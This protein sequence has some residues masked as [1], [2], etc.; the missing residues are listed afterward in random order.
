[1]APANN[2]PPERL[3]E[4]RAHPDFR[5]TVEAHCARRVQL[6][7][8]M[9]A[10]ARWMTRDL[11]IY[12]LANAVT[13]LDSLPGGATAATLL[14]ASQANGTSS[15]GRVT[16][17]ID[18]AQRLGGLSIP[19]GSEHWTRRRLIVRPALSD[20]IIDQH[21]AWLLSAARV[22]PELQAQADRFNDRIWLGRCNVV[23]TGLTVSF[24]HLFAAPELPMAL[25]TTR[26]GGMA[27]FCDL[28]SRQAKDRSRLLDSSSLSRNGLAQRNDI[29]RTQ[30]QRLLAD[31]E[32]AGLLTCTRD[33]VHFTQRV[34]EDAERLFAL[35]FHICR[36]AADI[37]AAIVAE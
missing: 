2:V 30:V 3:A 17:F 28:F 14:Q 34:S 25:F 37:V 29:S 36:L 21:R 15:R 7:A 26:D 33:R 8:E 10:I 24:Q 6:Q 31:G 16:K 19:P 23:T 20:P 4:I 32:A 5:A 35:G 9:D 13:I 11:G 1:M 18:Q 22:I 27:I 12:G